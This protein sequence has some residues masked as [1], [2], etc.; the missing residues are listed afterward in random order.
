MALLLCIRHVRLL[1]AQRQALLVRTSHSA[2]AVAPLRAAAPRVLLRFD[3]AAP[4]AILCSNPS[5]PPV[6]GRCAR[7]PTATVPR[8]IF[9]RRSR[10]PPLARCAPCSVGILYIFRAFFVGRR[11][12]PP[13]ESVLR[14]RLYKQPPAAALAL[15]SWH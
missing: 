14:G 8:R 1:V 15:V 3:M 4:R 2:D 9:P 6:A 5:R 12:F 13:L 10:C 11:P 7:A